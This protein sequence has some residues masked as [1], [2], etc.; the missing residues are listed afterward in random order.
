VPEQKTTQLSNSNLK[1]VAKEVVYN[2]MPAPPLNFA[3]YLLWAAHAD[4]QR[5]TG[6]ANFYVH[7]LADSLHEYLLS[8]AESEQDIEDA[9]AWIMSMPD[10]EMELHIDISGV[11][12]AMQRFRKEGEMVSTDYIDCACKTDY[13]KEAPRLAEIGNGYEIIC[14]RCR[15]PYL[16]SP[17]S[18][19]SDVMQAGLPFDEH[20]VRTIEFNRETVPPPF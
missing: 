7:S 8:F 15:I 20:A 2:E 3:E 16:E 19:V 9:R 14:E 13:I 12:P 17:F 1:G 4:Y 6:I 18:L 10:R 5:R 11:K